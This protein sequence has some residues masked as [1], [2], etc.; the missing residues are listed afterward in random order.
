MVNINQIVSSLNNTQKELDISSEK[1]SSGLKNQRAS[2]NPIDYAAEQESSAKIS[3]EAMRLLIL[4]S[5]LSNL[6]SIGSKVT[7]LQDAVQQLN[8]IV[9]QASSPGLKEMDIMS[10]K[11]SFDI[12]AQGVISQANAVASEE[13]MNGANV[14]TNSIKQLSSAFNTMDQKNITAVSSA[15]QVGM[16]VTIALNGKIGISLSNLEAEKILLESKSLSNKKQLNIYGDVD[17]NQEVTN[18]VSLKNQVDAT[19][20]ALEKI[21]QLSLFKVNQNGK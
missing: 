7:E 19:Y 11:S 3:D 17:F 13:G 10:L 20:S 1:I 2:N 15:M 12:I 16:D 4:E 6:N 9:R 5:K 18:N 21:S 14:I 8:D